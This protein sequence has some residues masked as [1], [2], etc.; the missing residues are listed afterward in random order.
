MRAAIEEVFGANQPVQRCRRH[1]ER[2]VVSYLPQQMQE[3]ALG[4]L[5]QAWQLSEKEGM[6]K[7][8]ALARNWEKGHPSA[9]ASLREGLAEMFTVGRLGLPPPL[10]RGLCST[11]V[12][13]SSFSGA[14]SRTRRVTHWQSGDMA[15]RWAAAGLMATA[16]QFR[17][18]MGYQHL[19][20]LAAA[21]NETEESIAKKRQV[22]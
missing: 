6:T 16:K 4:Q 12:I 20:M 8:E 11:N 15:L 18:I 3:Q 5:R 7:L 13:E 10:Q 22:G 9:A 1:K 17:R 14:R 21:L 19:W 2:N